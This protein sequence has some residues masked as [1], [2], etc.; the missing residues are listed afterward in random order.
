MRAG[1][2]MACAVRYLII[3]WSGE[4]S[5]EVLD[6]FVDRTPSRLLLVPKSVMVLGM[7]Q[8]KIST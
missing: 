2:E 4:S 1:K 7:G 6:D 5:V 8:K 3:T